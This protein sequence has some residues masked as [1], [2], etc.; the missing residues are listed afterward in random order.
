MFSSKT[1]TPATI[2]ETCKILS[3]CQLV[4]CDSGTLHVQPL[5]A[6][7]STAELAEII[8]CLSRASVTDGLQEIVFDLRHVKLI[9]P[10]WT[11]VLAM[12]IQFAR[13]FAAKCRLVS[14]NEQPA[15]AASLYRR[16]SELMKLIT[17]E[18]HPRIA[19]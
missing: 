18:T 11:I 3:V 19:A 5:A 14:L 2:D 9:G 16:N 6:T 4:A 12:L 1:K 13:C 8:R 15:A 17:W 10:Q 7:L